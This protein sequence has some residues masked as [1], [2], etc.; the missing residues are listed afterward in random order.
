VDWD[1]KVALIQ[2]QAADIERFIFLP[3]W[4]LKISRCTVDGNQAVYR[5][6]LAE[7]DLNYTILRLCGFMQGLI[8]QYA[9]PILERQAVFT[10]ESPVAHMDTQDIAKFVIAPLGRNGKA[11]FPVVGPVFER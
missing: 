1:G 7:A 8:G 4:M 3:F 5:A 2:P 10:G 9:I 6:I 11:S